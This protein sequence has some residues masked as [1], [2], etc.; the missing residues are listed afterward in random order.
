VL[1][2]D[3]LVLEGG[4]H[5]TLDSAGDRV[6]VACARARELKLGNATGRVYA[7]IE[8]VGSLTALLSAVDGVAQPCSSFAIRASPAPGSSIGTGTGIGTGTVSAADP[9]SSTSSADPDPAREPIWRS[10][11]APAMRTRGVVRARRSRA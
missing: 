2:G 4:L 9:T 10:I 5:A 7:D 1:Y 11:S 6:R 8:L 3:G